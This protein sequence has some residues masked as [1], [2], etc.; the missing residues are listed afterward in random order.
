MSLAHQSRGILK[1][2]PCLSQPRWR[3]ASTMRLKAAKDC[4]RLGLVQVVSRPRWAPILKDSL[5]ELTDP[6]SDLEAV[7]SSFLLAPCKGLV[8]M[9][10][11][12]DPEPLASAER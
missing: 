8:G 7:L 10:S 11:G 12:S 3:R 6:G 4:R 9:L 1:D 2:Q 5:Q